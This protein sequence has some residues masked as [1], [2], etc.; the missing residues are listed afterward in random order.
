[1]SSN[2]WEI[3]II[4]NHS[5]I[6]NLLFSSYEWRSQVGDSHQNIVQN[7]KWQFMGNACLQACLFACDKEIL[8]W[9]VSVPF[10]FYIYSSGLNIFEV[11]IFLYFLLFCWKSHHSLYEP[12][13]SF[14]GVPSSV[15]STCGWRNLG[16]GGNGRK[17]TP[18]RLWQKFIF[19]SSKF[20]AAVAL[21]IL[22]IRRH[23]NYQRLVN[24]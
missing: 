1:M 20:S 23:F 21:Y 8:R 2:I 4:G 10:T 13:H 11:Q 7:S 9:I 14:W 22:K 6:I 17:E 5:I 24:S 16:W 15:P 12:F 3:W 18:D 19:G